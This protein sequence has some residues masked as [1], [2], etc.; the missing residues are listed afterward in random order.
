MPRKIDDRGR[1]PLRNR[2][3]GGRE[4]WWGRNLPRICGK[5]TADGDVRASRSA[6][7][8]SRALC[9]EILEIR[10]V[11]ACTRR[12]LGLVVLFRCFF[13]IPLWIPWMDEA[14][15]EQT[16]SYMI[17]REKKEE[18]SKKRGADSTRLD[19]PV[20]S[21]ERMYILYIK[22]DYQIGERLIISSSRSCLCPLSLDRASP[23][24]SGQV[25]PA[26]FFA[27]TFAWPVDRQRFAVPFF[28]PIGRWMRKI[29]SERERERERCMEK[30]VSCCD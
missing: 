7:P 6:F 9:L 16:R 11:D 8:L 29:W 20:E 27:Q 21:I 23:L 24:P 2:P 28:S 14:P 15:R 22:T 12:V 10:R 25:S 5:S 13:F 4:R 17:R 30:D 26:G 3:R 19:V 18:K 1:D